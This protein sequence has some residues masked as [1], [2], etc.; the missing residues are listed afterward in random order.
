MGCSLQVD[1]AISL[2]AI[3]SLGEL[4]DPLPDVSLPAM[5]VPVRR[6]QLRICEQ[7]LVECVGGYAQGLRLFLEPVTMQIAVS[8][9]SRDDRRRRTLRRTLRGSGRRLTRTVR[10]SAAGSQDAGA[11]E[12]TASSLRVVLDRRPAAFRDPA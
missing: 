7:G 10:V 4:T 8:E 6:L 2:P 11:G 9:W 5:Q 1:I 12:R 3:H